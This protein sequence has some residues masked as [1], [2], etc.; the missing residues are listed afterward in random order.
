MR[1]AALLVI[2]F[3]VSACSS[4]ALTETCPTITSTG[5]SPM[6]IVS[7]QCV[8]TNTGVKLDCSGGND[9]CVC[10]ENDIA[11]ETVDFKSEFCDSTASQESV[12]ENANNACGWK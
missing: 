3:V 7:A 5:A 10:Y 2:A 6:C 8:G 4:R 1:K 9:K 12:L 11:G